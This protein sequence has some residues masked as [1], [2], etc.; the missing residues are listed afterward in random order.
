[1]KK[2]LLISTMFI[3][4]ISAICQN[5]VLE[6]VSSE[7]SLL[8]TENICG[9]WFWTSPDSSQSFEI[10]IKDINGVLKGSHCSSFNNGEFIDCI[11]TGFSISIEKTA[12]D[13]FEGTIKSGYSNTIGYIK[14]TYNPINKTVSF[15]LKTEPSGIFFIPKNIILE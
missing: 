14:L 13:V 1:M 11:N 7:P 5:T 6:P 2:L 15:Y 10:E 4:S 12:T 9:T 3:Y 8:G